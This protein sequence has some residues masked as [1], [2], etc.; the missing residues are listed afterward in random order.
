MSTATLPARGTVLGRIT[1]PG[2]S[3]PVALTV[4]NY[5]NG[6][7][8]IEATCADGEP[9]SRLSSN[10]VEA[11]MAPGE[12]AVKD[13]GENVQLAIFAFASGLFEATGRNVRTGHVTMPV[14]RLK[15][16]GKV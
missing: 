8:A 9:Y 7:L 11:E 16:K 14:W 13:Y 6:R 15:P 4:Y 10:V 2:E 12:F 1:I 3:E 5:S